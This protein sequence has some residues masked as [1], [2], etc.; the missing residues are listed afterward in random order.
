MPDTATHPE[1]GRPPSPGGSALP[2]IWMLCGSFSFACM[3]TLTYKLREEYDWQL[4]LLAR[5]FFPLVFSVGLALA[6]RVPLVFLRPRSLWLRSISGS[7]SMVCMFY[8]FTRMDVSHVFTLNNV[9]PIWVALLAWPVLGQRPTTAVWAAVA[10]SV[11]GVVLI[12]HLHSAEGIAALLAFS[13][14]V[15]TAVA[16]I[17]LHQ[18]HSIDARAIVAHFSGVAVLICSLTFFAV[19]RDTSLPGRFET[20]MLVLL[21][22]VGVAATIGQLFLTKA[23]A[24]GAPAKV[25]VVGLTQIVFSMVLES[26]LYSKGYDWQTLLGIA[27]V[28]IPTAW[29]MMHPAD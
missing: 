24:A 21:L 25:S 18:L 23:F 15:L 13:S 22:G 5:A 14:S 10:S 16:F 28:V 17:G 20:R 12:Q 29:V 3:G 2:Y 11:V 4:I 6:A 9:F 7:L 19:D 27:L 8:A 26:L 1:G